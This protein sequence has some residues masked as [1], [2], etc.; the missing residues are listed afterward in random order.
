MLFFKDEKNNS[1]EEKKETGGRGWAAKIERSE[2]KG[3]VK[4]ME[5]D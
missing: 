3:R 2:G 4:G 5:G 1:G